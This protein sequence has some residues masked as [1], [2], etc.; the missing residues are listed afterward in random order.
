MGRAWK[1]TVL[2]VEDDQLQRE[3]VSLIFEESDMHVIQ[4]MSGEAA[5]VVL[6]KA[7]PELTMMFIDV[8][9][10]G[11][12]SGIELAIIAKRRVPDIDVIVTSGQE[13]GEIPDDVLFMQKPWLPLELLREAERSCRRHGVH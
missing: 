12:M 4:C 10:E 6:E 11:E 7:G 2:V 9:L 3:L 5:V 8:D 1:H 13:V